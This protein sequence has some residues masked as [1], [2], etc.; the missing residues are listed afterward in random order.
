MY[1]QD[2]EDETSKRF[3]DLMRYRPAQRVLLTNSLILSLVLLL[4]MIA[5]SVFQAKPI[6]WSLDRDGGAWFI[7]CTVL[8]SLALVPILVNSLIIWSLKNWSSQR[9]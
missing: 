6:T 3:A 5:M 4:A 8:S 1:A 7:L 2:E 9:S